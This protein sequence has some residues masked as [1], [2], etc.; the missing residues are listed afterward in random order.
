MIWGVVTFPGSNCD[1]DCVHVLRDVLG[2]EAVAVWHEERSLDG[3]DAVVLPG[4]FSYGDYLRAGAI[5]ATAPVMAAVRAAA[6]RGVPVLGICN[7]FQILTEAGLLPGTLLRNHSLRF[8]CR[9]VWLRVEQTGTPFTRGLPV[10]EVLRMP[11]AHAEGCYAAAGGTLDL[12][13]ASGQVVFR[14]CDGRGRIVPQANPNGAARSIAGVCNAAGNV[15]GLMPHPERSAEA[16]LGSTDG[17]RLFEAV[18]TLA[19]SRC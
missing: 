13:E 19:V 16:I 3:L 15:V 14:Y 12:L 2:H 6:A 9:D 5:A 8:V 7:G 17:R 1:R 11:V 4:G 18:A 10:G